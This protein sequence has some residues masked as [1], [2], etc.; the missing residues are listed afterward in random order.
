MSQVYVAFERRDFIGYDKA[1][2][3]K[4]DERGEFFAGHRKNFVNL[5]ETHSTKTNN[6]FITRG[7]FQI[8][9]LISLNLLKPIDVIVEPDDGGF[10]AKSPG[11]P[12]YGFGDNI[13]E[14]IEMLKVEIETLYLDLN[15]DDNITDNWISIR[16]LLDGI[17]E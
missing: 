7:A 6:P 2:N 13:Y 10:I 11:L 3:A 12:L 14:A 5:L 17:I 15:E 4:I 16:A 9:N 1:E 8:K